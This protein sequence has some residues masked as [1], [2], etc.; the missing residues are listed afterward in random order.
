MGRRHYRQ[1]AL[2][3]GEEAE[4]ARN[5]VGAED[6]TSAPMRALNA[7]LS[8]LG[9]CERCGLLLPHECLPKKAHELPQRRFD[10]VE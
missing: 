4:L 7:R 10:H 3:P 2:T 1:H 9:R 6:E 5:T 8:A